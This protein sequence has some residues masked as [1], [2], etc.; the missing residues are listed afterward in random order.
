M[1]QQTSLTKV[2]YPTYKSLKEDGSRRSTGAIMVLIHPGPVAEGRKVRSWLYGDLSSAGSSHPP[3]GLCSLAAILKANGYGSHI[4][5]ADPL[6]LSTDETAEMAMKHNPRYL[7]ITSYTI[8]IKVAARIARRAKAIAKERGAELTTIIGGPHV[9][10]QGKETLERYHED[11]DY[12]V[13]GEGEI[14]IVE[15][16]DRLENGESVAEVPN[17]VYMEKGEA[18]RNRP[19]AQ[20]RDMDELPMPA[21]DLLPQL[22][23][24]YHPAGDNLL[25]LPSIAL[26]TSRGCPGKC[27]FC[28]PRGLGVDFRT[29]SAKYILGMMRHLQKNFGIRDVFIADD[30]FVFD[31]K[32][33]LELCRLLKEDKDLDMTWSVFARIDYVDKDLLVEMRSAGCWQVGYGLE[34]GSDKILKI[35]NKNQDVVRMENAIRWANEA[36]LVVRGMFM[37]GNF[38]ETPETLEETIAF[39][40]RNMIKDFH[41]TFFTPM[42]GT[43][44]FHQWKKYGTWNADPTEGATSSLHSLS[45]VPHGMTEAQLLYYQKR[46]YRAFVKPATLWYHF[47]KLFR[48][49]LTGFVLKGGMALI[50][51]TIFKRK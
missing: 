35:I 2:R 43:A 21:W 14:T 50:S 22:N 6:G 26:I 12:G 23:K 31:R 32:N 39:A 36:G 20:L 47:K 9:T 17:L 48:P 15:L 5:D 8:S 41:A 28:N 16:L 49:S 27:Y 7:G 29:H 24:F 44:S 45:F 13:L 51:Y 11:I 4:V 18:H 34:S 40:K 30:M 42:P 38:G 37:V 10:S 46:L 1:P 33:A 3:Q 19:R 25:R